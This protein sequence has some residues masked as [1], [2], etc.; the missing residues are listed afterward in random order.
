[1]EAALDVLAAEPTPDE[2]HRRSSAK[3]MVSEFYTAARQRQVD[4]RALQGNPFVFRGA[5]KAKPVQPVK[6]VKVVPKVPDDERQALE[7]VQTL[8][9]KS[10]IAG[11]QTVAMISSNI[12]GVGE[13]IKGWTVVRIDP[14]DVELSWKD[15]NHVLEMPK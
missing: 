11:D 10:I 6:P 12:V 13:T 14:K 5:P 15:K 9:L 7:A 1:M 4:L 3:A 2:A 8:R